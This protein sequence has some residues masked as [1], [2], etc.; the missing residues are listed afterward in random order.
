MLKEDIIISIKNVNKSFPG[1]KALDNACFEL[2]RGEVHALLGENG[3]GKS[4]LMKILTGLISKDEGEIL[5]NG[6]SI[7]GW[8][9]RESQKAGIAMIYQELHLV[10]NL[11]VA[12]NVFLGKEKKKHG[13][14][15]YPRMKE[16][17]NIILSQLGVDLD[18]EILVKDLSIAYQQI[19]EITK[20]ISLKAKVLIM[21]EP[22]APLTN[23]E[24]EMLFELIRKLKKS[25]VSIIYISHRLEELAQICDRATIFR[26][27]KY[28]STL[29]VMGTKKSQFISLMV[30]RKM[31]QLFPAAVPVSPE[32]PIVL[33]TE[34]LTTVKIKNISLRLKKGEIL[35]IAG[36]VGSGRT[37][38]LRALA[39]ADPVVS[40]KIFIQG[41]EVSIK[42]PADAIGYKIAMVPE[43]RKQQGLILGMSVQD[44]LIYPNLSK[45]S[46]A[47]FLHTKKI[48]Q[49]VGNTIKQLNIKTPTPGQ[50]T[51]FLSGGNQQKV[52]VGKWLLSEPDIILFDEPT[53]GI[54]VGAKFEIYCI[55]NELK[56]NGK[57]IIVVSSEM[58]ELIGMA[59]RLYI[60]CNGF[61]TGELNKSEMNEEAI[62]RYAADFSCHD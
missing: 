35:G 25:G 33:E 10:P 12:E 42:K 7:E 43:D 14:V 4:T 30:G 18:P 1:V 53:R 23:E 41:K 8:S 31:D 32:A 48:V 29:D 34:K 54:D 50:K 22:T 57:S 60:F 61:L 27:G 49:S 24:V 51:I 38:F 13:M 2:R 56:S 44:N 58:P 39:G 46:K 15:D 59:D 20:A 3:A 9:I 47:G 21:D 17:T 5:F 62:L 52:V 45:Y 11:T 26:D 16:E 36:L 19:V 28:I 55:L 6:K 37:E 40:G